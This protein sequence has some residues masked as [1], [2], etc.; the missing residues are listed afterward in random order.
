M[1]MVLAIFGI[2]VFAAVPFMEFFIR[3]IVLGIILVFLLGVRHMLHTQGKKEL[4]EVNERKRVDRIYLVY[5]LIGVVIFTGILQLN[6]T[7]RSVNTLHRNVLAVTPL[8]MDID[9]AVEAVNAVRRWGDLDLDANWQL[10]SYDR[11]VVN[12]FVEPGDTVIGTRLGIVR[13]F[14]FLR[15]E[16]RAVWIFDEHGV[17]MDIVVRK[18]F[19]PTRGTGLRFPLV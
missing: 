19:Q 3:Y 6:P 16:A 12:E 9:D 14:F 4:G 10:P 11:A 5:F 15:Y 1:K 18:D 13:Y 8:G 17:L 2:A 7:R